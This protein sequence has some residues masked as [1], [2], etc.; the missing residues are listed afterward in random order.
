MKI[1]VIHSSH[2]MSAFE[3]FLTRI[4][5]KLAATICK[6]LQAYAELNAIH[7]SRQLKVLKPKIWGYKGTIYKLRV[8]CGKESARIMFVKT[9][10]NDI[11]L[12]HGFI[13]KTRKTPNKDAKIAIGNLEQVKNQVKLSVF[14][15]EKYSNLANDH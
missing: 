1:L 3:L 6:K 13:K 2:E 14:P 8:D 12:L 11:V 4:S 15:L 9:V 7:M 10:D 5:S